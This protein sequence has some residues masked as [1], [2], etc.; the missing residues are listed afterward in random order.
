MDGTVLVRCGFHEIG[1]GAATVQA[2]IAAD[3]LGVPVEAVTVE[4]GDTDAA[5][6][7][8]G[9][10]VGADRQPWRRACCGPARS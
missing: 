4:H 5:G 3:A 6:R 10:R 2:Q 9:R 8:D 7:T 1:V